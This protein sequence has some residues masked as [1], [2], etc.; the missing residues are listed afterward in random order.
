MNSLKS[1]SLPRP[2]RAVALIPVCLA[3]LACTGCQTFSTT[4]RQWREQ[5]S[6]RYRDGLSAEQANNLAG[7]P[8]GV[9]FYPFLMRRER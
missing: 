6:G 3:L 7:G 2:V 5:Q 9:L 8:A 4:P 1:V